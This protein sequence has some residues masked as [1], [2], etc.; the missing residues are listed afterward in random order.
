MEVN[1]WD[2]ALGMDSDTWPLGRLCQMDPVKIT[3]IQEWLTPR[4]F[5][6]VQSFVGFVNFY[7]CFFQD[8]SHV[9]KPLHQ[10]MKKGE[11][12]Q[13][14]KDQQNTFEVLEHLIPSLLSLS[15]WTNMHPSS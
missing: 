9:S 1:G 11:V 10:L 15:R 13:W 14:T 4:N 6:K 3:G 7:W 12:W 8:F 2:L 5:T